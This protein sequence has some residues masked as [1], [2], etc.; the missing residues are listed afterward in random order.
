VKAGI[1]AI[2]NEAYWP[3][4]DGF[5]DKKNVQAMKIMDLF[6]VGHIGDKIE[7]LGALLGIEVRK[8][9]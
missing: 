3:Q 5:L 6:G 4:F 8:V 2:G 1:F 7:K 9:C